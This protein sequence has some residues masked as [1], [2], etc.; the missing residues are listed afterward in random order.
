MDFIRFRQEVRFEA[1]KAVETV[2]LWRTTYEYNKFLRE[3]K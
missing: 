1:S 3:V 2:G